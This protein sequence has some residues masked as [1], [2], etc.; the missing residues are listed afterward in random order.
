MKIYSLLSNAIF[1]PDS[2][3][4][5]ISL[6]IYVYVVRAQERTILIGPASKSKIVLILLK[7]IGSPNFI[8]RKQEV[9]Y[10]IIYVHANCFILIV[11]NIVEIVIWVK[12]VCSLK[13]KDVHYSI[14]LF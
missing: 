6:I 7:C 10:T 4:G 12:K 2:S 8:T 11:L 3:N 14:I 13:L 9:L 1:T 5:T